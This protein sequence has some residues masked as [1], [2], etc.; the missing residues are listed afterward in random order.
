MPKLAT[1]VQYEPALEGLND[2]RPLQLAD[3]G[4]VV[5]PYPVL[6]KN[7]PSTG[8]PAV[9]M[10]AR[11]SQ[12]GALL[13]SV[14]NVYSAYE[15]IRLNFDVD[16]LEQVVEFSQRIGFVLCV[17]IV[18]HRGSDLWWSEATYTAKFKKISQTAPTFLKFVGSDLYVLMELRNGIPTLTMD[19]HGFY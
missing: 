13:K 18:H 12:Q 14:S 11:C 3:E 8:K 17:P 19:F 2:I 5:I 6:C 9:G 1:P 4:K 15:K 16:N 10:F 7:P